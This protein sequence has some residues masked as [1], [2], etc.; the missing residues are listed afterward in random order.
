MDVYDVVEL[1]E[2]VP[3]EH[4]AAGAVGTIIHIFDRDPV[5]YE[6]EFTDEDGRTV[7]MLTLTAAQLRP[8]TRGG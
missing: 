6:V 1:Q 5:A 3:H 8:S 2:A 7:S 4:L